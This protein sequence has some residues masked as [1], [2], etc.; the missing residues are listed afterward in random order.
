MVKL[1]GTQEYAVFDTQTKL[2][3]GISLCWFGL[4]EDLLTVK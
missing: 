4:Y 3:I 2:V 1:Y